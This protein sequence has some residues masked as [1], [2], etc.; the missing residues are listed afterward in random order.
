MVKVKRNTL[1]L[2]GLEPHRRTD[3]FKISIPLRTLK[4]FSRI[5]YCD[6][7]IPFSYFT[8]NGI[9]IQP[10]EVRKKLGKKVLAGETI[11]LDDDKVVVHFENRHF[12]PFKK[13]QPD[14]PVTEEQDDLRDLLAG[15]IFDIIDV[16][17]AN[18]EKSNFKNITFH[19]RKEHILI[20]TWEY[21]IFISWDEHGYYISFANGSKVID[22]DVFKNNEDFNLSIRRMGSCTVFVSVPNHESIKK[23]FELAFKCD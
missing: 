5:T 11:N 19:D 9:S 3:S 16:I 14:S 6:E 17:E 22:D 8:N 1:C 2:M 4:M 21:L 18:S 7:E 15:D 23:V 13:S 10:F 12:R 20:T